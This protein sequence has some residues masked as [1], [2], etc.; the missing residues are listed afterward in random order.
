MRLAGAI[1]IGGTTIK[2]GIIAEDGAIVTRREIPTSAGGEPRAIV[3]DIAA[4][5][6]PLIEAQAAGD[7]PVPA[8]GVAVAGFLDGT[9]DSMI[10]NANMPLLCG[11]PL[12]R[13]LEERLGL[14][15]RLEV[16][17]NAAVIAEHRFGAGRG[18]ERLLGVTVGTGMGGAVMI[19]GDLL[20]YTGQCA[21]DVGHIIVAPEGRRCTCGSRGCLEAMVCAAALT[22]RAGGRAARE[23]ID[24]ARSGDRASLDAV[25]ETGRWLGLGLAALSP[26]FAPETIVV[27]G[28]IATAGDLLLEP[29]RASYRAHAAS[30]VSDRVTIAGSA[31]AG[32]AGMVGAGSHALDPSR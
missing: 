17:S 14:D 1:D 11:F 7:G 13:T 18:A 8:V 28:G 12:R 20:R 3:N 2:L 21:G 9:R 25:A 32:W 26:I 4:A 16:D 5:L 31:H 10:E 6:R 24:A 30:G 22:E 19:A 15:C 23:V 27:G 29:A